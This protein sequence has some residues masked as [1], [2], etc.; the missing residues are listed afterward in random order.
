MSDLFYKTKMLEMLSGSASCFKTIP[1][2]PTINVM[3]TVNLA[4][5]NLHNQGHID[6]R[7]LKMLT[8]S[9]EARCPSLYGLP[10]IHKPSISLR[11]IV[12]GNENPT[13]PISIFIDYL[14]QPYAISSD[15]YLKDTTELL[16]ILSNIT[17]PL[18]NEYTLLLFNLDVVGMYT[19]IPLDEACRDVY[20]RVSID[21]SF[22]TRGKTRHSTHLLSVLLRLTLFNNFFQFNNTF[23]HQILGIAMGTPCACTVSDIFICLF[24]TKALKDYPN[25]PLIYKQYRDDGFGIWT[26]GP[27]K[28]LAFLDFLNSLHPTI[29]FTMNSG[30]SIEYLDARISFDLFGRLK[31]ETFYKDTETFEFL[32]PNSN[33]PAHCKNNI[34]L[35]QNI[36]HLRLNSSPNTYMHHSNLL[37]YNLLK[38]GYNARILARKMSVYNFKHRSTLLKYKSRATLKRV[39]LV[40]TY[41]ELLPNMNK[42]FKD[43]LD[44]LSFTEDDIQMIGGPPLMGYTISPSLGKNLIRAKYPAP[45]RSKS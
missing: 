27:E 35:S 38:R 17:L 15:F 44:L 45:V 19:N 43:E 23:Y 8:P 5:T 11:P 4:L 37:R 34:A 13:E 28:L 14:L 30:R 40:L 42:L 25:Q 31:S 41:H 10:K 20:E 2:D 1:A 16:N 21:P 26:H 29:K 3:D 24:M 36:R 22:L 12:S 39:P 9:I 7:L 18:N 32:H 33:H 6:S